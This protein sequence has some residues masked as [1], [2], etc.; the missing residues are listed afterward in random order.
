MAPLTSLEGQTGLPR[1]FA[2]TF[3]LAQKLKNGRVDF[4]LPDGRVFRVDG[5]NPGPVGEMH[6]HSDDVFARLVREGDLGFADSYLDGSWTT[7]DLQAVMDVIPT[8]NDEM[9]EQF[10]GMFL[11]RAYER[12]R[13]WMNNNSKA[14]AKKNI[15]YHYDLGND[16][17]A[18]WLDD[19]MTYSSAIFETG[20]ESLENAQTAKYKSM[21][22]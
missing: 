14:Q 2:T 13:H 11:V 16:C 17:Y 9:Y 6:V 5:P 18:R 21:V 1:Y 22:D 10:P 7:P 8:D 12:L 3:G 4:H 20:Q 15:S 19:T